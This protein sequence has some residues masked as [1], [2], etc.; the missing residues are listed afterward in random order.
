MKAG[1]KRTRRVHIDRLDLDLR[2]ITPEAARAAAHALGPA[3]ARAL[4]TGGAPPRSRERIDAGRI[5][6]PASADGP[7]LA[8][9]IAERIAKHA[10]GP[11]S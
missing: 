10:R 2:G 6:S 7:R 3:L 8:T 11:R 9:D 4:A 1:E 5:A